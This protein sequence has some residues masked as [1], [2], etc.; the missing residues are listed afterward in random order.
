MALGVGARSSLI[1]G[2]RSPGSMYTSGPGT[3]QY[4]TSTCCM[5]ERQARPSSSLIPL[6]SVLPSCNAATRSQ[7]RA[8]Q[9]TSD[10]PDY[11]TYCT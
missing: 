6:S 10:G 4:C 2:E 11:S 7:G 1:H 3:G 9:E 8:N 5:A